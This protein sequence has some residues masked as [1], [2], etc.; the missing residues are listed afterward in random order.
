MFRILLSVSIALSLAFAQPAAGQSLTL[1]AALKQALQ[2]RA[3]YKA[4]LVNVTLAGRQNEKIRAQWRPQLSASADLRWNTQLQTSVL[5]IGEFG[6]PNTPA[7]AKQEIQLGLPFNYSLGVQAEQK[8]YDPLRRID[9]RIN[10]GKADLE[11]LNLENVARNIRYEVAEAYYA[12]LY[13][14]E[15]VEL[16]T[17]RVQQAELNV[18]VVEVQ[19]R[20]GT[21]LAQEADRFALDLANA[22]FA[23]RKA[24]QDQQLALEQLQYRMGAPLGGNLQLAE[25]LAQLAADTL[26]LATAPTAIRLE[27]RVEDANLTLNTLNEARWQLRNR[28][29]VSAYANYTLLHLND[30]PNPFEAG[31]WF[32]FNYIGIRATAPLYDGRQAKLEAQDYTLRQQLNAINRQRIQADIDY[33]VQRQQK[34][35]AQARIDWQQSR[36]NTELARR[37]LAADRVRYE[38]GAIR[39]NELKNTELALKEA[40][41]NQLTATYNLL[42]AHLNL[43]KALGL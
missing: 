31:T 38:Q 37:L 28:P 29:T 34:T 5:P 27:L 23:L 18:A 16:A 26:T 40:E 3:E 7:D 9:E 8:V 33:E 4:Q 24:E 19:R 13:S 21:V 41:D 20:N 1:S 6:L 43:Q 10:D 11:A 36:E 15:Q 17:A 39:Q 25:T 42:L 14:R 30:G 32:P 12:A 35:L 2:N 22:R